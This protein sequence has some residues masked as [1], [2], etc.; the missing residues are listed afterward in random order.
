MRQNN[1]MGKRWLELVRRFAGRPP[2]AFVRFAGRQLQGAWVQARIPGLAARLDPVRL[3]RHL[4]TSSI[5]DFW[6]AMSGAPVLGAAGP[7]DPATLESLCSGAMARIRAAAE[8]AAIREV[9]MLGSGPIRLGAPI[10][11]HTDF[12]SGR[13]WP[14]GPARQIDVLD[15]ARD[16]DV[17]VP[18]ELSRLQWL[19][20]LGQA[21]LM[22]G[23]ERWAEAARAVI[24]DWI[25]GNPVAE[26]VNWSS[27]ME[28]A[29]R[30]IVLVWLAHAFA[31]ARAWADDGFRF[32][33]L[34]TLYLHGAFVAGN[35]EWAD[36]NG[37][38][39]LADAAGLTVLGLALGA[40][41]GCAPQRWQSLGWG[42]LVAEMPQQVLPDGVDFEGSAGYHRLALELFLLPA[43]WRRARG[44]DIAQSY[45]RTLSAMARFVATAARP[46]GTAPLWGDGDDGR[47][48]PLGLGRRQDHRPLV[49]A[50]AAAFNDDEL[51]AM[52][53]GDREDAFWLL[54]PNAASCIPERP[55]RP[56][57]STAFRESGVYVMRVRDDWVF[58]DAGPVGM[59]GR[60]GHGHNDCLSFEAVLTGQAVIVDCG[61][62]V[63]SGSVA[64]RNRFRG[65]AAHNTPM[66]DGAEQ[67]RLVRPEYLWVL[68]DDA[69]PRVIR[70]ETG[71]ARDV[72]IAAHSGY[73]RL[74]SPV[75]PIRALLLDK[76][77]HRLLVVDRFDGR[78][79]HAVEVPF[80]LPPGAA[81]EATG[82]GAWRIHIAGR[83]FLL[84]SRAEPPWQTGLRP[85]WHSPAYGIRHPSAAI[86]FSRR[87]PLASLA[88][89]I[90][91]ET[92]SLD[93]LRNWL[94]RTSAEFLPANGSGVDR[95]KP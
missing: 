26:G 68:R 43:L 69:R 22:D 2:S 18:W 86:V 8:K 73:A 47:V 46:D 72:L 4:N 38:H 91:P 31:G 21:Y 62:F 44:L 55:R 28:A 50:I 54:G 58:A 24:D 23:E 75:T 42:L 52:V 79:A 29:L 53:D 14:D 33:V 88:V 15:L 67:N 64:E 1:G 63:Y 90:G 61:T 57:V 36:V 12:R 95:D 71:D 93:E 11:W 49:C 48:L 51:L 10:D 85:A 32:R 74:P 70:W 20:P 45:R 17:K 76:R 40:C 5:G 80:H 65:I 30:A 81:A 56:A 60:G 66:V 34:K 35:L 37:N 89:G 77:D 87:G 41:G 25:A 92:A 39:L 59:R 83:T 3:C 82:D 6:H 19:L 27:A 13:R 84:M 16:S 94:A 7:V 9:D 78:G